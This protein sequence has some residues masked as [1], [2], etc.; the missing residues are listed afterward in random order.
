MA[1]V[2]KHYANERLIRENVIRHL[3]KGYIVTEVR[4]DRGHPNGAEIHKVL[5]NGV[6]EIYNERTEVLCTKIVA[7]P[8]Q[9]ERYFEYGKAPWWLVDKARDNRRKGYCI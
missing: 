2:S 6:I 9:I 3:G 7:T 4:W 8:S 5:S 1:Q